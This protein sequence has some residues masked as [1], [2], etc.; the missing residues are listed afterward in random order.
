MKKLG[1][2][3]KFIF[4]RSIRGKMTE[5][6]CELTLTKRINPSDFDK[7]SDD[8]E[9]DKDKDEDKDDEDEDE[10]KSSIKKTK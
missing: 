2:K 6:Q 8:T 5:K 7:D 9:D 4:K 3:I 1:D 10:A